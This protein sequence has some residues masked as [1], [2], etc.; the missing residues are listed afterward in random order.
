MYPHAPSPLDTERVLRDLLHVERVEHAV[1]ACRRTVAN[2]DRTASLSSHLRHTR[3]RLADWR[4]YLRASPETVA[5]GR[6]LLRRLEQHLGTP[7]PV[8]TLHVMLG[9][10]S[11]YLREAVVE[12]L[13]ARTAA[14][15]T[16]AWIFAADDHVPPV[17]EPAI[18]ALSQVG[19]R[20]LAPY[21]SAWARQ[22]YTPRQQRWRDAVR[23]RMA[24]A[25]GRQ[26]LLHEARTCEHAGGLRALQVLLRQGP[27]SVAEWDHLVTAR[28]AFV[29]REAT[30]PCVT[31]GHTAA[32]LTLAQD[33]RV[34]VRHALVVALCRTPERH[35]DLLRSLHRDRSSRVRTYALAYARH[36]PEALRDADRM[37]RSQVPHEVR[38]GLT[39]LLPLGAPDA[40]E[41]LTAAL[42]H[43]ASSVRRTAL[44]ELASADKLTEAHL[45]ALSDEPDPSVWRE[46]L[47]RA[48]RSSQ[49]STATLVR[50]TVPPRRSVLRQLPRILKRLTL[51]DAAPAYVHGLVRAKDERHLRMHL[52]QHI[53]R[54]ITAGWQ[55]PSP[56]QKAAVRRA[57]EDVRRA[58][59]DAQ[60]ET[61]TR[62]CQLMDVQPVL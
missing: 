22:A 25:E 2:L 37:C 31:A 38:R 54:T 30:A 47:T 15:A 23:S 12:Q 61:L 18:A 34:M 44:S 26:A 8:D 24:C 32:M 28:S 39:H 10:P 16:G 59:H 7:L 49:I 48:A 27:P 62:L 3:G 40:V 50:L 33:P 60:D 46:I 14:E 36:D 56:P 17:A 42:K 29:R 45:E 43:P 52:E 51:F 13:V 4:G 21:V 6:D 1:T 58:G 57:F 11:G 5:E 35:R 53:H 55:T 9:M 19:P 20:R 41:R